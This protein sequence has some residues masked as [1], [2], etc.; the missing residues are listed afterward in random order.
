MFSIRIPWLWPSMKFLGNEYFRTKCLHYCKVSYLD[1]NPNHFKIPVSKNPAVTLMFRFSR[2]F[3]WGTL[4]PRLLRFLFQ[5]RSVALDSHEQMGCQLHEDI[6][7]FSRTWKWPWNHHFLHSVS[8][9]NKNCS[10]TYHICFVDS[11]WFSLTCEINRPWWLPERGHGC[12]VWHVDEW[13][14]FTYFFQVITREHLEPF[15]PES[16]ALC[17]GASQTRTERLRDIKKIQHRYL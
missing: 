17:K 7:Q 11:L 1:F 8:R 4:Q 13:Y 15:L 5:Y 2:G 3:M 9:Q 14:I 16:S 10:R 12:M 6:L